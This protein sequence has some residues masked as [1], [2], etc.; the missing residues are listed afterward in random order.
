M[1]LGLQIVKESADDNG[2][3]TVLATVD[4]S[5]A[6]ASPYLKQVH[7]SHK[8]SGRLRQRQA[9]YARL[10]LTIP[11]FPPEENGTYSCQIHYMDHPADSEHSTWKADVYVD[12][13]MAVVTEKRGF[14]VRKSQGV[15]VI[16]SSD[17]VNDT[18]GPM[19]L[20]S[21]SISAANGACFVSWNR[22]NETET[23]S[24]KLFG[25]HFEA[26]ETQV[27]LQ[28][29][30]PEVTC[31]ILPNYTCTVVTPAG[32]A[33]S[34]AQHLPLGDK[35]QQKSDR[36]R[37]T[38][39]PTEASKTAVSA[40]CGNTEHLSSDDSTIVVKIVLPV[41]FVIAIII[42]ITIIIC[43]RKHRKSDRDVNK[44]W[45]A[46]CCC[47]PGDR[48]HL[49]N[50]L[51]HSCPTIGK[52][53]GSQKLST[54]PSAPIKSDT[55][56]E[57]TDNAQNKLL[58]NAPKDS[59][60][61]LQCSSSE[62]H[63]CVLRADSSSPVSLRKPDIGEVSVEI[64]GLDS[65]SCVTRETQESDNSV[66]DINSEKLVNTEA[67]LGKEGDCE[68][69]CSRKNSEEEQPLV[70]CSRTD[71]MVRSSSSS[72]KLCHHVPRTPIQVTEDPNQNTMLV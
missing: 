2:T 20:S 37:K 57:V 44:G 35:C 31:T 66:N 30:I 69:R 36:S 11:A 10:Q 67:G 58:E 63:G 62:N 23:C 49:H 52:G 33:E 5:V 40:T 4:G 51:K 50:N 48:G 29:H 65:K 72:T 17:V 43:C 3:D 61:A 14:S 59:E 22:V 12:S 64:T 19:A 55:K 26:L 56:D 34:I 9:R 18:R 68:R 60:D 6:E 21:I 39:Q 28:V 13:S 70:S 24:P 8:I 27:T 25:A 15:H 42:I 54:H 71:G 1:L 45:K 53:D 7:P 47:L 16:C 41:I 46:R 32:K 38:D